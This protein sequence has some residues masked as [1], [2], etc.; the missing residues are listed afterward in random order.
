MTGR[1]PAQGSRYAD[2]LL[3]L[4]ADA[5]AAEGTGH[6]MRT[7]ALAQAWRDGGG[8]AR[9]LLAEAP[10]ALAG[11]IASEGIEVVRV[12][13]EP[14]SRDDAATL[15]D[16]LT[17]EPGA[18][19][20]VDG[21]Q[22]DGE[23]LAGL[24]PDGDRVLVIDDKGDKGTYPVG[25]VLNQNA[26]ADRG[27]YPADADACFLLGLRFV[28]LRREFVPSPPPR[29]VPAVARRLLVTFGGADPTGMTRR[30][31]A[32]LRRL[33]GGLRSVLDVR[34]VVGAANAEAARIEDAAAD[35]ALGGRVGVERAVDDMPAL[36]AWADLAVTSGGTTVWELA[37]L[38][39]PA[40]VVETVPVERLLVGGLRAVGLFGHLGPEAELDAQTLADEIAS[41][42]EDV[43]WRTTM[44]ERGMAL[45]DGAGARRVADA[46]AGLDRDE[47]REEDA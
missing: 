43:A 33:P 40:L 1:D 41:K 28:L 10:A 19:A 36:M 9:W 32:A 45:V 29:I 14:G 21:L 20:V 31:L 3:L 27:A 2:R 47:R 23:F 24:A 35:P 8:R 5:T 34:I 39:C 12:D 6:L 44:S 4:R 42:A 37:R 38:G 13:G 46:L 16:A 25:W 11:R 22:F 7:L 30:T 26:H 18:R 15:R 17:N